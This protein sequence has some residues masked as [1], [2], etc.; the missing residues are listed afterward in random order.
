METHFLENT[1]LFR[2]VSESE[3]KEMLTC[4]GGDVRSFEKGC[5][6]Y[7]MGDVVQSLG[8]VLSGNVHIENDDF[9][10]N[11][12]LLD[13]VGPGQIFAETYACVSGE[14][15]MVN[16]T[17]SE[18]TEVLFL[19][20]GRLLQTCSNACSHHSKLI[21]N[22][23]AASAQKNLSLSR[24]IFH[25]SAKSIRGRLLSYLSYQALRQD[26]HCFEIPFNRQQLA[27]YLSVDRSALSNEL[28]KMQKEGILTV[29]KNRFCL[30]H[31]VYPE[32]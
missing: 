14:P 11:R 10:G 32:A 16:V 12:S 30:S 23:L 22:L 19:N 8:V 2:G 7:H 3:I 15:L 27:D 26:S 28:S 4:L 9:W 29:R 17:A 1:I 31:E 25:T 24:R 20:I 5:V 21:R 18:K 6:I 13:S